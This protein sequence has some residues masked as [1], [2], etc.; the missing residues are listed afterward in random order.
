VLLWFFVWSIFDFFS[1]AEQRPGDAY[2]ST[3]KVLVTS[4]QV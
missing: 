1:G 3:S 2:I 4:V